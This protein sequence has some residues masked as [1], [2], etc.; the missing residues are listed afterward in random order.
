VALVRERE[1]ER[2][3]RKR[4]KGKDY[5]KKEEKGRE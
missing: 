5:E 4:L 1:R 3:G 2:E